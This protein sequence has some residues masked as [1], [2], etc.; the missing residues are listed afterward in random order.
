MNNISQLNDVNGNVTTDPVVIA[1]TF[2]DFFGNVAEKLLRVESPM[3]YLGSRNQHSS[4]MTPVI[5]LEILNIT[6]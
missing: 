6:S 2:S 3:D 5:P 4:F 1:N